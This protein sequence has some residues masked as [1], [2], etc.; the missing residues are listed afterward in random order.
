[1]GPR[2]VVLHSGTKDT[3]AA[4]LAKVLADGIASK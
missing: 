1:M 4:K 3:W 2:G